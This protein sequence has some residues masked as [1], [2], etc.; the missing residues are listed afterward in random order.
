MSK[1]AM[2]LRREEGA[3]AVIFAICLVVIIAAV[4]LTVDVGGLMLRRRELVNASDSAALSAAQTCAVGGTDGRFANPEAAAD[5]EAL[6][7]SPLKGADVSGT[8]ITDM[9]TCGLPSGHVTVT[10][11]SQQAL[12]FAP[13]LG[14]RNSSPVSTAATASWGATG[15]AS[16][17]PLVF[18][19]IDAN[20]PF[21]SCKI[22]QADF[23]GKT[24]VLWYTN[25]TPG[26]ASFGFLNLGLVS[27][28]GWATDSNS[29]RCDNRWNIQPVLYG[30][31]ANDVPDLNYPDPS[32]ACA[33]SG[34]G[35]WNSTYQGTTFQDF[36]NQNQP[37]R[38]FPIA[39]QTVFQGNSDFAYN[40]IGYTH[41]K[42]MAIYNGN[43][44]QIQGTTGTCSFVATRPG[45]FDLT[46]ACGTHLLADISNVGVTGGHFNYDAATG[47]LKINGSGAPPTVTFN[48]PNFDGACGPIPAAIQSHGS[49]VHCV[50]VQW[51]GVHLG[52][53]PSPG[54]DFGNVAEV[55]CDLNYH[56]CLDQNG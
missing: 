19:N 10:Y 22:P 52:G 36:V 15:A 56:S 31:G 12:Y 24:C 27:Q 20:D 54:A 44:P 16:P 23:K 47:S 18:S 43:D 7:N 53:K 42:L 25:P 3:V 39:A 46:T 13:V 6:A 40:I 55:L 45:T 21:N 28:N 32:W 38:D 50:V 9:T 5:A 14:F 11:T 33:Y 51:L 26:A 30:P 8:N 49:D 17:I 4:A 37:E 29:L 41:L 1:P 48:Y 34:N 2:D 35:V